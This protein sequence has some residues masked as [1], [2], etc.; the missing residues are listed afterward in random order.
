M[1]KLLA[2]KDFKRWFVRSSLG[3]WHDL[4]SRLS[5]LLKA[6]PSLTTNSNRDVSEIQ[7]DVQREMGLTA[8]SGAG[9]D[10]TE[11]SLIG[12]SE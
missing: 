8:G 5:R 7:A 1:G 12:G 6:D 3:S 9:S 2:R 4:G 11:A 10:E